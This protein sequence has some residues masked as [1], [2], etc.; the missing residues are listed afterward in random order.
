M[1]EEWDWNWDLTDMQEDED[2]M[3][4]CAEQYEHGCED[5]P[6]Y[7]CPYRDNWWTDP[8]DEAEKGESKTET[9]PK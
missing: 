9:T 1:T 4:S 6:E 8:M 2:D 5:C 3:I 7:D